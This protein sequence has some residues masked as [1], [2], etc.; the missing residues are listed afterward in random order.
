M[1]KNIIILSI[2]GL[3][4]TSCGSDITSLNDDPKTALTATANNVF[5]GGVVGTANQ[6]NTS[7]MNSN[8]FRFF[9]QMLADVQYLEGGAYKLRKRDLPDAQWDALYGQ[10]QN[11]E[12]AKSAAQAEN[13]D[14]AVKANKLAA[15]E[16]MQI[17]CYQLLVDSF[18][19]VPYS[20][21]LRI[22][23]IRSPKY[24]D[25]KTIY[26][27]LLKRLDIVIGKINT[28][29][30]AFGADDFVYGGNMANWKKFA[31]AL[32]IKLGINLAD[33]DPAL[34]KSAVESGYQLGTFANESESA[35]I[36]YNSSGVYTSP[37]YRD[38]ALSGRVD[39][40]ASDIYVAALQK[41][42]D[43]RIYSYYTKVNG[44]IK[45]GKFGVTNTSAAG[46]MSLI[47]PNV[48]TADSYGY[49]SDY[50][51][52]EFILAEAAARGYAVG[53][54]AA[55]HFKNALSASLDLWG[56]SGADKDAYLMANDYN[57]LSGTYKEKIGIQAWHSMYNRGFE[58]WTFSRR[59]DFPMLETHNS[60]SD[61]LPTRL[62]YPVKEYS[63]NETNMKAAVQKLPSKTDSQGDK[64]FWDK[65]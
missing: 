48:Y 12:T 61:P 65:N 62:I 41:D 37:A 50:V 14:A 42:N 11:F 21:A 9:T 40:C 49:F 45:P 15:I 3:V 60:A 44:A 7:S 52:I 59:L 29:A 27:D 2:L 6:M 10:L 63:V 8:Q 31:A 28:N 30:G 25:A 17:Y 47:N 26:V 36:K 32:K 20:E 58:A 5:A 4:L 57:S 16:I 56:I 35:R 55:T 22:T 13:I 51:E 39:Y 46:T 19:D 43:P 54:D 23:E 34:S 38:L 1:K 18:G 64:V 33:V 53:A 24:D